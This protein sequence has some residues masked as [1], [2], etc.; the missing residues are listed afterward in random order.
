MQHPI[1]VL[2][3]FYHFTVVVLVAKFEVPSQIVADIVGIA[4][5]ISNTDRTHSCLLGMELTGVI[6]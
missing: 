5:L 4:V 1:F 6:N 2:I 3:I